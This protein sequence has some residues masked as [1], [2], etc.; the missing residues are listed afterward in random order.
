MVGGLGGEFDGDG[1]C[2]PAFLLCLNDSHDTWYACI[3]FG[4][5]F[6]SVKKVESS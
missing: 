2:I 5:W 1:E 6:G 3:V 4:E